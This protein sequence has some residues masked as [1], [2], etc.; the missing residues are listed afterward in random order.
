MN[1]LGQML[2]SQKLFI[3][4]EQNAHIAQGSVDKWTDFNKVYNPL[5]GFHTHLGDSIVYNCDLGLNWT[6][7]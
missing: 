5:A 6:L 4:Y 3:Q 2:H 7:K 1:V